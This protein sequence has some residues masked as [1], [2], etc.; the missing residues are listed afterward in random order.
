VRPG[1]QLRIE[2]R[3]LKHKGPVWKVGARGLVDGNVV[4]DATLM[5]HV[6][7]KAATRSLPAD[8]GASES[9]AG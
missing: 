7:D 5:C 9:Q 3:V 6:A 4:A 8:P 2:L 1:D